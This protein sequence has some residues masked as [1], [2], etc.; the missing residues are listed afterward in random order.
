[1][2]EASAR[3]EKCAARGRERERRRKDA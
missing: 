2:S 3:C 1:M